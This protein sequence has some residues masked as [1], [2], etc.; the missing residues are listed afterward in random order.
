MLGVNYY[1]WAT[2]DVAAA[3]GSVQ[4][5]VT[6]LTGVSVLVLVV[7]YY[8]VLD[9]CFVSRSWSVKKNFI[10][11]DERLQDL[12]EEDEMRLEK[13]ERKQRKNYNNVNLSHDGQS[14]VEL[15][16]VDR[17]ESTTTMARTNF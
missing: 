14:V 5:A 16:T 8:V 3:A 15:N 13:K 9:R 1:A 2:T 10:E 6:M 7:T 11:M 12:L 17:R 4:V